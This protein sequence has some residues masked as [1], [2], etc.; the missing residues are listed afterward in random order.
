MRFSS[1]RYLIREGFRNIWQ[2]RF[3]AIASIGVLMSCLLIT[4]RGVPGFSQ[5]RSRVRFDL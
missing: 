5:H 4:G 3:M 2:N 1:I